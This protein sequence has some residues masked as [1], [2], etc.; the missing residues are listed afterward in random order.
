M[1]SESVPIDLGLAVVLTRLPSH[2]SLFSLPTVGGH[3][4]TTPTTTTHLHFHVFGSVEVKVRSD[5]F[6]PEVVP[7]GFRVPSEDL[8]PTQLEPLTPP[9]SRPTMLPPGS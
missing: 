2:R 4:S 9:V 6:T 8:L 1:V 7:T 3:P 5:D